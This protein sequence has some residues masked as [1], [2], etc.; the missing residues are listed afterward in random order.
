MLIFFSTRQ[1]LHC[2]YYTMSGINTD[3]D[4][5]SVSLDSIS[6]LGGI[7]SPLSTILVTTSW[8]GTGVMSVFF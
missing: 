2:R 7:T 3:G 6:F 8:K 1:V 5:G 4:A